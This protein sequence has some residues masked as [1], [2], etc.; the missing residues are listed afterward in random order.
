M[1][2][3]RG[4]LGTRQAICQVQ[5]LIFNSKSIQHIFA[6]VTPGYKKCHAVPRENDFFLAV[7][8]ETIIGNFTAL[9][10]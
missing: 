8:M 7:L 3:S 10:L 5:E 1:L 9:I 2:L 4:R 6:V